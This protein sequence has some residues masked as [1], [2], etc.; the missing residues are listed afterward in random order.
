MNR[1]ALYLI[2]FV[3]WTAGM[4]F[5]GREWRDRSCDLAASKSQTTAA[6]GETKAVQAARTAE[7]AADTRQADIA[8]AYER[9]KHDAQATSDRVAADLL[10]GN[11]RLRKELGAL[12]TAQL[13]GSAASASVDHAAAE[14]GAEVAAA[15]IGVGAQSDAQLAACQAVVR[16]DRQ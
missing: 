1:P 9:G 7:H 11:L 16:S 10:G 5:V 8:E 2:A 13:S 12:Y 4:F 15:A 6:K 14:R 3:L